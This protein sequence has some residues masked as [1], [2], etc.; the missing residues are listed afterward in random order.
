VLAAGAES[1]V[2]AAGVADKP[3]AGG[4]TLDDS[5]ELDV[6]APPPLAIVGGAA[7]TD[8]GSSFTGRAV[9][10]RSGAIWPASPMAE[11]ARDRKRVLRATPNSPSTST[12][13]PTKSPETVSNRRRLDHG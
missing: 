13:T 12:N 11:M 2:E 10:T 3:A 7:A 1:F 6:A 8:D 4:A 5:R 9:L